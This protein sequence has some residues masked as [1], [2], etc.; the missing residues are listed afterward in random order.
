MV[1]LEALDKEYYYILLMSIFTFLIIENTHGLAVFSF[2]L[3]SLFM[4]FFIIPRLKHLFS[5]SLLGT[6]SSLGCFYGI[7][8]IVFIL[9]NNLSMDTYMVFI[10]NFILDILVVGLII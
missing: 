9:Y 2:S 7:F 1:F 5:S 6:L 10:L 4:Y 8:F 3:I